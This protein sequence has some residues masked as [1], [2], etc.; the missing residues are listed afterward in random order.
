MAR[1]ALI[2][3]VAFAAASAA[4]AATGT[5]RITV[6]VVPVDSFRLVPALSGAGAR[7]S[8]AHNAEAAVKLTAE[9]S[10]SVDIKSGSGSTPCVEN[11]ARDVFTRVSAGVRRDTVSYSARAASSSVPLPAPAGLTVLYTSLEE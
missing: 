5:S 9:C 6:R 11:S 2:L 8:F 3:A 10:A 1:K 7:L 4:Q